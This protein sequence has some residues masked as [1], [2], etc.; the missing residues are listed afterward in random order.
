MIAVSYQVIVS[1]KRGAKA[2]LL[3][4][5]M[6]TLENA[7]IH[8]ND[9]SLEQS[10][11]IKYNQQLG[12][13]KKAIIGFEIL[14]DEEGLDE[15]SLIKDFNDRLFD[16]K[17]VDAVFK[18]RDTNLFAR[19]DTL[20]NDLF[21]IEMKLR[22]AITYI[23]LD[24]YGTDYFDLLK[25][26]NVKSL[27]D[28]KNNLL[29]RGESKPEFLKKRLENEFFFIL[30]NQYSKLGEIKPLK[31]E[32]LA[33]I[34]EN[35][36]NFDEFRK[37]LYARGIKKQQYRDFIGSIKV[38]MEMLEDIRN[39]FAHNRGLKPDEVINFDRVKEETLAKIDGFLTGLK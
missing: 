19:L 23:F 25:E 17:H 2:K 38:D 6:E 12:D 34:A 32:D 22:E 35:A 30:F 7:G 8:Y 3:H 39:C 27:F 33:N 16:N 9:E 28:V 21:E 4:V 11:R 15:E 24:T 26:T 10:I 5:L 31:V 29:E 1:T 37:S 36:R 13:S 18:F 14:V 20:Q